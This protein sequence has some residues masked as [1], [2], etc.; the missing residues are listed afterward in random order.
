M[1]EKLLEKFNKLSRFNPGCT[2]SYSGLYSICPEIDPWLGLDTE[3]ISNVNQINRFP[4]PING[5]LH[6]LKYIPFTLFMHFDVIFNALWGRVT[7]LRLKLDVRKF[8]P[9]LLVKDIY[10]NLTIESCVWRQKVI[11]LKRKTYSNKRIGK[12]KLNAILQ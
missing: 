1:L 10:I 9:G 12:A 2:G 7:Y 8:T 5:A 3:L 6:C 4:Y 11:V